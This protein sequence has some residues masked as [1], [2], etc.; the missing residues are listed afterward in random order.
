MYYLAPYIYSI[1]LTL[2]NDV[3]IRSFYAYSVGH[4]VTISYTVGMSAHSR[5]AREQNP[6][7]NKMSTPSPFIKFSVQVGIF[8]GII[9]QDPSVSNSSQLLTSAQ[10]FFLTKGPAFHVTANFYIIGFLTGWSYFSMSFDRLAAKV[11]CDWLSFGMWRVQTETL[12]LHIF[13]SHFA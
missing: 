5:S 4:E 9:H 11:E 6:L 7:S 1:I 12:L 3:S 2:Y 8:L 13:L 10:C